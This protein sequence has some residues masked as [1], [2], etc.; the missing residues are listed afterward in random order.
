MNQMLVDTRR[1]VQCGPLSSCACL[2][3]FEMRPG[4]IQ[5]LQIDFTGYL[6][7]VPGFNLSAIE[8]AEVIDLFKN[9]PAP[10]A[11]TDIMLTSG[12]PVDPPVHQPG[13]VNILEGKAIEVLVWT[14]PDLPVGR[15][16][17]IDFLLAFV[18]CSGRKLNLRECMIVLIVNV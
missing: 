7:T 1:G 4:E 18:D 5:P 9:P 16:F 3:P 6:G 8:E 10:A 15:C 11:D 12:L 14:S 2:G 13:F 17:R